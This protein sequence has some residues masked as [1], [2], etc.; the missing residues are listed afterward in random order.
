M[1]TRHA[2]AGPFT[3]GADPDDPIDR[4]IAALNQHIRLQR[5]DQIERVRLGKDDNVVDAGQRG[6]HFR[7][8]GF[9]HDGPIGRL[10]QALGGRIA[11]DP[12][13]EQIAERLGRLQIPRV[14]DVHE[15]ETPV[16]EDDALLVPARL[17]EQGNQLRRG[18]DFRHTP[19]IPTAW[20]D[21]K[22]TPLVTADWRAW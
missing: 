14:A 11:V 3:D 2:H 5:R 9:S 16:G 20:S 19:I 10:V 6:K 1:K 22:T 17:L 13:H 18:H 8:V 7:A 15:V 12:D 4:P 21:G